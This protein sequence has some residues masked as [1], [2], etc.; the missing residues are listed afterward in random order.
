MSSLYFQVCAFFIWVLITIVYFSKQRVK[1]LETRIYS[2]LLFI[3]FF[4]LFFDITIIVLTYLEPIE[5]LPVIKVLNKFYFSSILMWILMLCK[6]VVNISYDLEINNKKLYK[7]LDKINF[8]FYISFV[9]IIFMLPVYIYNE[10]GIMYSYGESLNFLLI[11][12]GIYALII[13]GCVVLKFRTLKNKKYMPVFI[14]IILIAL[15]FIVNRVSPDLLLTTP[16]MTYIVLIMY[17]TIENPDMKL[18]NELNIAKS[19]ADKANNAKSDFLS[20]MSHEIRTPLNA[21][22]GFSQALKEDDDLP[23]SSKSEVNDIIMASNG[24]L[25][26][27]N[28]ILD[29]SKI[30]AGK[31][32]I[33]NKE[34][35][36]AQLWNDLIS[37]TKARL[38]DKPLDL[39]VKYDESIPKVL[40]GDSARIK[41]VILNILTNSIKYTKEGYVDFRVSSFIKNDICRLIISVEDSGIG[42]KA[43]KIENL[44]TKF[45]RLDEDKNATIEGTGLGLA[46]TKKLLDL[47]NG[48]ITVQSK[49]GEGSKFTVIIDQK[50]VHNPTITNVVN[51]PKIENDITFEGKRILVVDDNKINLK[52]AIR[53]LR[54]Y[55]VIV[56]L[57]ESG[58]ECIDKVVEGVK[59][60]LILLDDMMPKISGIETLK[61]LKKIEG[62]NIPTIAFTANA[63][64][65]VKE[66]YL[67]EGFDDY[68][69]KPM[70][71]SELT[72]ILQKFINN[73]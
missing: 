21:I 54:S 69:S 13:V 32:E 36:F 5:Y 46:I 4:S 40:Y 63:I 37:L 64:T 33:I 2:Y 43:E 3:T 60:D 48:Q 10:N 9:I 62:F 59:Y 49:Y 14:L 68:L 47:M 27:V 34:Y 18:I 19:Q 66:K 51:N 24:L 65:G 23:E 42:I 28:G 73:N 41:Q 11:S 31:L 70:Q 55:K 7:K 25:E 61:K 22:V 6:Y 8:L 15:N 56:D 57:V 1:S 45:Q 67:E 29:F 12:A 72:E 52:V 38:G 17:H 20:N 50:I 16:I 44:F 39:Q 30:E 53:L 26:I 35:Y 58:Q 71:K